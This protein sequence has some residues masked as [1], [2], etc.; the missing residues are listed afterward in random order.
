MRTVIP[1]II[2]LFVGLSCTGTTI[3]DTLPLP[4]EEN[5]SSGLFETNGW[6]DE[7][8]NWQIAGQS[9]NAAPSAEFRFSPYITDYSLSLT[10]AAFDATGF[11][12]GEIFI[13]FDLKLTDNQANNWLWKFM[14]AT[15]GLRFTV[16]HRMEA[17]T[18]VRS[19]LRLLTRQEG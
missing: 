17:S 19:I 8:D 10:S 9:G 1:L 18:G 3:T 5:F 14:M 6:I 16:I 11:I 13:D 2:A 7:G 15:S 12:A 4:F